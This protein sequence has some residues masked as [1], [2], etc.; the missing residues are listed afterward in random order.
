MANIQSP[1][2]REFLDPS[3]SFAGNCHIWLYLL[4]FG[5]EPQTLF[6]L[7]ERLHRPNPKRRSTVNSTMDPAKLAKL[8]AQAASNRIGTL[9]S[10]TSG[11]VFAVCVCAIVYVWPADASVRL[12]GKGTVRRKIVRKSKPSNTQDDKK[13]Q[14]AL[15]KLNVQPITGVEEVNMFRE[16]GNV[17]HFSAPKGTTSR[18]PVRDDDYIV[19]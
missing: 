3:I 11:R 12:G 5:G 4:L 8:Q 10:A 2:T 13:L 17:L 16:D 18:C 7:Q 6:F 14:G 15:K 1:H 19:R 9:V